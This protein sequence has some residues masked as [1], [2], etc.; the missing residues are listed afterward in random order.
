MQ[1][2]FHNQFAATLSSSAIKYFP[3]TGVP[4]PNYD[5]Q[6]VPQYVPRN[7]PTIQEEEEQLKYN[8]SQ[9]THPDFFRSAANQVHPQFY[10]VPRNKE[11]SDDEMVLRTEYF[12]IYS[13]DRDRESGE[14]Q[15][16]FS[17]RLPSQIKNVKQIRLVYCTYPN[18]NNVLLEPYLV[19]RLENLSSGKTIH[20]NNKVTD[21]AL[22]LIIP[23]TTIAN[24]IHADTSDIQP[25]ELILRDSNL[26]NVHKLDIAIKTVDD[27]F[28]DFGTD[29]VPP[30]APDKALQLSI[31]IEIQYYEAPSGNLNMTPVF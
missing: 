12:V 20:S 16:R 8:Q 3:G 19:L 1:D 27:A 18:T 30:N 21:G 15:T 24:F 4:I 28:F 9:I 14:T 29:T 31:G 23:D 10:K 6:G 5:Q 7:I 17:Y 26:I 22:A 25:R 13:G 11:R 2:S